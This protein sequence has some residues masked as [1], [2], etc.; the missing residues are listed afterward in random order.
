MG[1]RY[2]CLQWM[3]WIFIP[4]QA[5]GCPASSRQAEQVS[6]LVRSCPIV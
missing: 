4:M 1:T 5:V 2:A 3:G 6:V